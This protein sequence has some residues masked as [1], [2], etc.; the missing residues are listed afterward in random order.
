MNPF[1]GG[2]ADVQ[3]EDALWGRW[4]PYLDLPLS[5]LLGFGYPGGCLL[6]SV[7]PLPEN[8]FTVKSSLVACCPIP[9]GISIKNGSRAIWRSV[10]GYYT[11]PCSIPLVIRPRSFKL[12]HYIFPSPSSYQRS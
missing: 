9:P 11:T 8:C 10:G 12:I 5:E 3:S 1:S 7:P 4:L 2:M 6:R